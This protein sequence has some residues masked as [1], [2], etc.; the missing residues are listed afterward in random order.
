[1]GLTVPR[2]RNGSFDPAVVKKYKRTLGPIEDKI[3][4]IKWHNRPLESVYPI[5]FFDAT[6]YKV[7]SEGK[8]TNKAAYTRLALDI[9]GRKNLLDLWVCEADG[10]NFWLSVPTELKIAEFRIYL[11][12]V[13][14]D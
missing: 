3:I 7:T 10:P 9:A 6:H 1:M 4:S 13:L 12:L 5:V 14:M 11:L 8:V 2:D